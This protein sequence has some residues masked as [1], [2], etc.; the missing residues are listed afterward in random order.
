MGSAL[1][2]FGALAKAQLVERACAQRRLRLKIAAQ[3][4]GLLQTCNRRGV[5]ATAIKRDKS[6]T[7]GDYLEETSPRHDRAARLRR[8]RDRR[9]SCPAVRAGAARFHLDR[10]LRRRER[11]RVVQR[12]QR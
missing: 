4:P 10:Y 9:R 5:K 6:V 3:S 7:L 2:R 1:A 12:Q 11:R 8:R